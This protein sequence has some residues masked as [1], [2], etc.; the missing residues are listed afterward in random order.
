MI[1]KIPHFSA[2]TRVAAAFAAF[3]TVAAPR[4]W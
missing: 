4:K 2:V 3:I 1:N